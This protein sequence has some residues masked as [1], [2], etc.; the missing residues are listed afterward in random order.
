MQVQKVQNNN[1][2]PNFSGYVHKSLQTYIRDAVRTECN[3]LVSE[4]N[5]DKVE[6]DA[7]KLRDI[8]ETGK[9][10][11]NK[12]KTFIKPHHKKS[13]VTLD[14]GGLIKITN[15]IAQSKVNVYKSFT[16]QGYNYG[17]GI[18]PAIWIKSRD[19]VICSFPQLR[20]LEILEQIADDM[21]STVNP[22]EI[23]KCFLTLAESELK[24]NAFYKNGTGLIGK[25]KT[26][27]QAKKT[28]KFAQ[29]IGV[30]TE[31][32]KDAEIYFQNIKEAKKREQNNKAM[33][34]Y[35][36]QIEEKN[37]Q[38]LKDILDSKKS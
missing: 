7:D 21:L 31:F 29:E 10:V 27:R 23:D 25:Y 22:K 9:R 1:F 34:K 15:P 8:Y 32:K 20:D 16:Q 6:V 11:L 18:I 5:K 19:N 38:I 30:E 12:F 17:S 13:A 28:D 4:A 2:N 37:N 24:Q 26:M 35:S 3:M 36:K 33:A 14:E